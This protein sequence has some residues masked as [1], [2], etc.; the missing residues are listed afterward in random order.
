MLSSKFG[1]NPRSQGWGGGGHDCDNLEE[2][3]SLPGV[4]RL[5]LMACIFTS[6]GVGRACGIGFSD[7]TLG[8]SEVS[9]TPQPGAEI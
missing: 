2:H 6:P 5:F 7:S 9:L 3:G 1:T 8:G 4:P